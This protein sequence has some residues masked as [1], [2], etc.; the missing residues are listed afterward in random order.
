MHTAGRSASLPML[1]LL[2]LGSGGDDLA[3]RSSV[4]GRSKARLPDQSQAAQAHDGGLGNHDDG[5]GDEGTDDTSNG[6]GDG[7]TGVVVA[8]RGGGI[9]W[10][11][12]DV[13]SALASGAAA[14]AAP[15]GSV[16]DGEAVHARLELGPW[17]GGA[18]LAEERQ[19][20]GRVVGGG[21]VGEVVADAEVLRS[22][23]RAR[24]GGGGGGIC[25]DELKDHGGGVVDETLKVRAEVGEVG[26]AEKGH[27]GAVG[28]ELDAEGDGGGVAGDDGAEGLD[29]L[30]GEDGAGD[31][32][33]GAAPVEGQVP[34]LDGGEVEEAQEG[35]V[36][37]E[38]VGGD[39]GVVDGGDVDVV[40]DWG[41]TRAGRAEGLAET[42]REEQEAGGGVDVRV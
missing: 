8:G 23:G 1:D 2:G 16:L 17:Q 13:G 29:D 19:D 36:C 9:G 6:A 26:H 12:G 3:R 41:E 4:A 30:A 7:V 14:D 28:A 21:A 22:V 34:L 32:A 38:V 11:G 37:E 31:G 33:D 42:R 35:G 15:V 20:G 39:G 25:D 24:G 10:G 5:E 40:E 27:E 18:G